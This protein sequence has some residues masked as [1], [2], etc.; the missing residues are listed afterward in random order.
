MTAPLPKLIE[1]RVL[2]DLISVNAPHLE[3][4]CIVDLSS[5][6]S[7]LAGHIPGAIHLPAQA[8]ISGQPPAPGR[9]PSKEQL[10]KVF[11]YLGLKE[12]T[13]FIIYDDEGGGWAGRFLWTLDVIGHSRFTYVNGGIIAWRAEGLAVEVTEN[14]AQATNP[15]IHINTLYIAEIPDILAN[16]HQENFVVWDARSPEEFRGEKSFA[17][18]AGHIPGAINCEWTSLMDT[19]NGYKILADAEERLGMLGIREGQDIIT[20]CQTHHR[21]GF[22]YMLGKLLGFNIRAYHGSWSEWGNH[23]ETPVETSF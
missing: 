13:H 21:S 17:K 14:N 1:P 7:Y 11:G 23:P 16:L 10:Q 5:E 22:T 6:Q 12:N 15:E 20:H 3:N 4:T 8:I 18:K 19:D 9:L 2:H